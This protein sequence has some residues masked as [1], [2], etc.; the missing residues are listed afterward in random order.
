MTYE[1]VCTACGHAW[2]AE[3]RIS[4]APLK[5]CPNC[6][7][8]AAKR[9]VSGGAGFILKGGG[10]YADLYSSAKPPSKDGGSQD[11]G[12]AKPAKKPDAAAATPAGSTAAA[13]TPAASS[14]EASKPAAGT[15]PAATPS[16]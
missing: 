4:E 9:Q 3:Q 8:E 14:S 15:K 11:S 5:S 10:W 12:D 6:H 7:Q 1:Y 2:E 16:S 13:S